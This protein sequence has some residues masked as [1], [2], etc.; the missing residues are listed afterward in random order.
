MHYGFKLQAA[1]VHSLLFSSLSSLLPPLQRTLCD[2]NPSLCFESLLRALVSCTTSAQ[3]S[4]VM[5]HPLASGSICIDDKTSQTQHMQRVRPSGF[6]QIG[7]VYSAQ[8]G[9][10][11]V[12]LMCCHK[13]LAV[14]RKLHTP[15][16]LETYC[17]TSFSSHPRAAH[18]PFDRRRD[19]PFSILS[20]LYSHLPQHVLWKN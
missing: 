12:R 10:C 15:F 14:A 8:Y 16:G 13:T 11:F 19:A 5:S 3:A 7:Q 9:H 2:P 20:V 1:H 18:H 17:L 6:Q 4:S